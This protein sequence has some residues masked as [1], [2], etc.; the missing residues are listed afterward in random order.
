MSAAAFA[1]I[2]A[3]AAWHLLGGHKPFICFSCAYPRRAERRGTPSC[4]AYPD[5]GCR[6]CCLS[7]GAPPS[8]L[9]HRLTVSSQLSERKTQCSSFHTETR[10][11]VLSVL[12]SDS[13]L[14]AHPCSSCLPPYCWQPYHSAW[15]GPPLPGR[16]PSTLSG[17]MSSVALPGRA[18]TPPTG[19]TIPALALVPAKLRR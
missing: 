7:K 11:P 16:L 13:L 2:R 3:D 1:R 5:R 6:A 18:S 14:V 9:N 15:E 17:V 19:F 10:I 12:A 4:L 8:S